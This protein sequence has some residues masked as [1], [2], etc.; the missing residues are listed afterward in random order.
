[1][2]VTSKS[3]ARFRLLRAQCFFGC[4]MKMG[5]RGPLELVL[6]K[7]LPY[8]HPAADLYSWILVELCIFNNLASWR[9]TCQL[10]SSKTLGTSRLA[11]HHVTEWEICLNHLR[12]ESLRQ[13]FGVAG[14]KN[15]E[16]NKIK[17]L[18]QAKWSRGSTVGVVTRLRAGRSGV[19]I[20]IRV[21]DTF[22]LEN[23]QKR[24][25]THPDSYSF[26][27]EAVS[28]EESGRGTK[29]ATHLN[30]VPR[31]TLRLLMSYIYAAPILDVS[32]SH[33]TTQHSR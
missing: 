25:E 23:D 28:R 22:L 33:T 18:N 14:L 20:P 6:C 11:T 15:W 1:M 17:C 3:S 30:L 32:R 8:E 19:Q 9:N 31:L 21:R 4:E 29:L 2:K 5:T 27:T 24:S 7:E 16:I 26:G 13:T 10:A 12:S